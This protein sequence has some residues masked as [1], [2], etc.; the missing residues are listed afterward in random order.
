MRSSSSRILAVTPPTRNLGTSCTEQSPV[1]QIGP[2]FGAG[3]APHV[4]VVV[5]PRASPVDIARARGVT[6]R[7]AYTHALN[8]FAGPLHEAARARLLRDHRVVRIEADAPLHGA[9]LTLQKNAEWGLDRI[10]QRSASSAVRVRLLMMDVEGAEVDV[11]RGGERWIAQERPVIIA[12]AHHNK[13]E[14]LR[15]LE[16]YVTACTRRWVASAT[17]AR[18]HPAAIHP[19]RMC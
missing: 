8:G 13:H 9:E 6:A 1:E 17:S 19:S 5:E 10:D 4:I 11:L 2:N 18:P 16:D 3:G 12:E 15:T 14:L 7:H